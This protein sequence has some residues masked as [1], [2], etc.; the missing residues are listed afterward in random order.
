MVSTN[1]LYQQRLK[2]NMVAELSK[3]NDNVLLLVLFRLQMFTP[4]YSTEIPKSVVSNFKI[5]KQKNE[6]WLKRLK[7][8]CL[9]VG[10]L[11][12]FITSVSSTNSSSC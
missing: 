7:T 10:F 8:Y 2:S 1:R 5:L 6:T 9:L 12:W 11:H 3:T 4:S